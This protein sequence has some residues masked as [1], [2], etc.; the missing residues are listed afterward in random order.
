MAREKNEE[1]AGA[2]RARPHDFFFGA[3]LEAAHRDHDDLFR[4][5]SQL[6]SSGG[7]VAEHE[8]VIMGSTS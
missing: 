7:G 5:R 3:V 6:L 8:V 4:E 1:P 2:M